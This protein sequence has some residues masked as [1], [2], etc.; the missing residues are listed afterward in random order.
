V[1]AADDLADA[2][3]EGGDRH[4]VNSFIVCVAVIKHVCFRLFKQ[5]L[6]MQTSN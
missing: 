5:R 2:V 4:A 1:N 3:L 6:R